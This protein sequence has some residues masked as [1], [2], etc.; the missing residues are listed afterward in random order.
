LDGGA[1]LDR[2]SET[3][4][5]QL[6]VHRLGQRAVAGQEVEV[7]REKIPGLP[8]AA[9]VVAKVLLHVGHQQPV[10][11]DSLRK[12][13]EELAALSARVRGGKR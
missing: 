12:R 13:E 9:L 11:T 4:L 3:H 7:P 6:S 1:R 5:R 2:P 10:H 8:T